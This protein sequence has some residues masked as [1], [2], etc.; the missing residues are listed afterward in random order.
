MIRTT[1][2]DGRQKWVS[3][4]GYTVETGHITDQCRTYKTDAMYR[5]STCAL[6][7]ITAFHS[8]FECAKIQNP[9][10]QQEEVKIILID[11]DG[12]E[13]HDMENSGNE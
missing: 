10:R 9:N 12:F 8:K 5:C 13:L 6:G 3:K 4:E 11:E 7:R 1:G 2:T